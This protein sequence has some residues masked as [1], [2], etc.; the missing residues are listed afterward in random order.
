MSGLAF[1]VAGPLLVSRYLNEP[2]YDK[3]MRWSAHG[4]AVPGWQ[5]QRSVWFRLNLV[6]FSTGALAFTSFVVALL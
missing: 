1:Y 5:Q 3:I 6:R 2:W 4:D